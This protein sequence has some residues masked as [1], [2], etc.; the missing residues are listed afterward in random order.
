MKT[1]QLFGIFKQ[2]AKDFS[3][4]SAP[5]LGASVAF[6]TI[7]SISPLFIILI[8]IASLW[9]GAEA[10]RGQ[11]QAPLT[12]LLGPKS[13]DFIQSMISQPGTQKNGIIATVIAVITLLLGS[14]G[15]FLE[16]QAALNRVWEVKQAP[17]GGIWSF[18]KHR[19]LSFAMVLTIG[20]LLLVSLV[21]T[22][23]ISSF[24]KVLSGATPQ[25]EVISQILNFVVSFGVITLLFA[26]IFK[27][28]PDVHLPWSDVWFG[29][30]ITSMLFVIGKFALGYYL[31]KK[32]V[33]SPFGAAGSLVTV[34]LWVYYSAQIL[35]FGAEIT[36]AHAKEH[37]S[38]IVPKQHAEVNHEDHRKDESPTDGLK[39][40]APRPHPVH[41][42]HAPTPGLVFSSVFLL[43]ALALPKALRRRV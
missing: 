6:Y 39:P 7:F 42:G 23:A 38:K 2:A 16:L 5:R 34:L 1:R 13:A 14:S 20:F 28:M 8:A 4:D 10:A 33:N 36:Q 27:Y 37:G 22:A 21:L 12:G 35:F 17:G 29:A 9:Y 15:V 40:K 18:I 26:L 24:G 43:L 41:E 19:V 32:S 3:A 25:L 30:A 11:L 31:A